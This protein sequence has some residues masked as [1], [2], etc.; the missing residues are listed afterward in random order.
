MS[1]RLL[2][3]D[4]EPAIAWIFK[5]VLEGHGFAVETASSAAAGKEALK[6]AA[7]DVVITDLK[8][9]TPTAGYEVVH[10][11]V[12][13]KPAPA[14]I[15]MSAYPALGYDWQQHGAHAFFEKPVPIQQ[16][17]RKINQLLAS[18]RIAPA[19]K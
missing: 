13:K 7:F 12:S 11:A 10:A 14:T 19:H 17:L 3:V 18:R 16:L 6:T 4:D 9:E 15:I 2:L 8:M 5:Q 1:L